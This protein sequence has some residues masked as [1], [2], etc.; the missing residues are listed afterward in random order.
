MEYNKRLFT[1]VN[2]IN[3]KVATLSKQLESVDVPVN[4]LK[5]INRQLKH[6]QPI[7][8][9]FKVY[10]KLI[11][12]A[13]QV[14]KIIIDN[15]DADLVQMAKSELETFKIHITDIE[16]KLKLLLLPND[17]NNS[18]NVIV[19]MRP[20]AGGDEASIF[21]ADLFDTYRRFA[22]DQK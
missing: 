8:E 5:E 17:P 9:A 13:M 20:A 16:K 15:Q 4:Q 14:E 21:V 10:K 1:A 11:D 7:V 18:R 3:D 2:V 6:N 22:E 12:D 19:E